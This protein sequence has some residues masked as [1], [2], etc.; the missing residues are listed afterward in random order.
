MM[1]MTISSRM[2]LA[3]SL[4]FYSATVVVSWKIFEDGSTVP[5]LVS[6]VGLAAAATVWTFIYSRSRRAESRR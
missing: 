3:A 2:A 6:G 5:R 4:V 1:K